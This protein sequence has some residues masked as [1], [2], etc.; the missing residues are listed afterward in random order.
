MDYNSVSDD[1]VTSNTSY[2]GEVGPTKLRDSSCIDGSIDGDTVLGGRV[3]RSECRRSVP[4]F[5]DDNPLLQELTSCCLELDSTITYLDGVL[6]Y[7]PPGAIH[8]EAIDE[9]VPQ[10]LEELNDLYA[11]MQDPNWRANDDNLTAK[12]QWSKE[13]MTKLALLAADLHRELMSLHNKMRSSN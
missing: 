5:D 4:K 10:L 12:L 3:E 6:S 2:S 8:R 7:V 9:A 13:K 1:D 11:L